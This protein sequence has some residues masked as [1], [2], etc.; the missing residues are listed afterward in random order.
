MVDTLLWQFMLLQQHQSLYQKVKTEILELEKMSRLEILIFKYLELEE[1]HI[2]LGM[3]V[4]LKEF[5]KK[6]K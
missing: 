3:K 1:E 2:G 4:K 5:Q 6:Q